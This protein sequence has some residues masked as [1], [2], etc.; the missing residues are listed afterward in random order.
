MNDK[1]A[2]IGTGLVGCG[3]A[4]VFARAGFRVALFD[5]QA[6]A[7]QTADRGIGQSLRDLDSFSLL[8]EPPEQV[9]A[10]ME[11]ADSLEHALAGARYVQESV[12]ERVDVKR[13][14]Y[15]AMDPLLGPDALVGSSSSGIPPS[16][17]TQDV[18]AG[19]RCLVA[20]PVN[21]PYLVPLVE[22]VPAPWTSA[23]TVDAVH[24]LMTQVGQVPIRVRREVEGF[25]LNRLQMALLNEA[26]RL[27][28][29]GCVCVEDADKTVAFGL[30]LRWSFM[31]PFETIDL[32]A[33]QGVRDYAQRFGAL[34][35]RIVNSRPTPQPPWSEALV[36]QVERERR[37]RLPADQLGA[38]R[39]WRDRR[40]MAL[41]AHRRSQPTGDRD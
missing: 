22:L 39:V 31:G 24:A 16:Q 15:A 21:P 37:E 19:A 40:L 12:F 35:Q 18:S 14:V 3:W 7:L 13:A 9:Q 6:G 20:H 29:D 5:D 26:W 4:I 28:E 30:G 25:I 38:R 1:V 33:P 8:D 11:W 27:V 2:I 23:A 32:N 41:L 10:R 36:D 34:G 17:F